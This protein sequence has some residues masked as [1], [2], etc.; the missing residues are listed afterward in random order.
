MA[1][2]EPETSLQ[3]VEQVWR[4]VCHWDAAW[5]PLVVR[6]GGLAQKR[7]LPLQ[8]AQMTA[9]GEEHQP[10]L[11]QRRYLLWSGEPD[12]THS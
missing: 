3:P 12:G 6:E 11:R 10:A 9:E 8:K 2:T 4:T 5:L 1:L 7:E